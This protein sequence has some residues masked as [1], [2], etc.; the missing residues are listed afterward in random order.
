[1]QLECLGQWKIFIHL[2]GCRTCDFPACSI[3]PQPQA[4][5]SIETS[6]DFQRTIRRY[7]PE[8]KT[9]GS[10]I[11]TDTVKSTCKVLVCGSLRS[12]LGSQCSHRAFRKL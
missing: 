6:V 9:P 5:Y 12:K 1:V 10:E 4:T 11:I 7:I 8:D 3:V 2:I